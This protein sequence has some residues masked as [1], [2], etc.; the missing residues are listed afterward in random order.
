[1]VVARP[2][3][4]DKAR[5]GVG[6]FGAPRSGTALGAASEKRPVLQRPLW[7]PERSDASGPFPEQTTMTG[8]QVVWWPGGR[9]NAT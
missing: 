3:P 2:G 6:R 4:M 8:E 5:G 1:M 9:E 7:G